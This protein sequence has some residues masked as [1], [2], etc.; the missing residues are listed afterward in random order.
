M[1]MVTF[2]PRPVDIHGIFTCFHLR[3][4]CSNLNLAIIYYQGWDRRVLLASGQAGKPNRNCQRL[5]PYSSEYSSFDRLFKFA[6]LTN[7][8]R[9]TVL[10]AQNRGKLVANNDNGPT[11][12]SSFFASTTST[13]PAILTSLV[14]VDETN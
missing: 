7:C 3:G 4:R 12:A 14:R 9:T 8:K 11:D 1:N 6:Q 13:T 10:L 5:I 2:P